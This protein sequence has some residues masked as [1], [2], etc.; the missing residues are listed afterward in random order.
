MGSAT[1]ADM[2]KP[3]H[4]VTI[5]QPFYIG[6]YEV[7]QW[8]WRAVMTTTIDEQRRKIRTDAKGLVALPMAGE[9]DD[10]AAYYASWQEA[11][12]FV[13]RLNT[14]NDGH[15]TGCLRKANNMA[16]RR[17]HWKIGLLT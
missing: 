3:A 15:F 1:G 9:G 8:Q 13:Q 4:S 7:T 16:G 11:R 5:T 2:E 10:R 14:L 12:T 6:R 17:F